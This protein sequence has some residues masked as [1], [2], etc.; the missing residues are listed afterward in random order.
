MQKVQT[1][2]RKKEREKERKKKLIMRERG[3]ESMPERK[4]DTVD[5]KCNVY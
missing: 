3:S 4:K 2:E 1:Q 5:I